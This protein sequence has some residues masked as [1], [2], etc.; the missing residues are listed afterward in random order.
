MNHD[1]AGRYTGAQATFLDSECLRQSQLLRGLLWSFKAP[2]SAI[3]TP[4]FCTR[5]NPEDI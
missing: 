4:E 2:L 5:V 3:E 1:I